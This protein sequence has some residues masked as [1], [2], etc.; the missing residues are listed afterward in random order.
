M[1]NFIHNFSPSPILVDFGFVQIH[2]YGLFIALAIVFAWLLF[3]YLAKWNAWD[4]K[5]TENVILS[6][7][8]GAVLGARIYYIVYAWQFYREDCLSIFKI[9]EGGLA[10]HGALIGG[11]VALLIYCRIKKVAVLPWLDIFAVVLPLSQA[12]GRW[13]NYFNQEIF[14]KPTTLPW[15]IPITLDK[16]PEAYLLDNYF[17]PTFLYES[18]LN[19][20]LFALLFF[21]WRKWSAKNP[22]SIFLLYLAVY[23]LIR[24][25]MEFLRT[26]YSPELFGIR[27]AQGLSGMLVIVVVFIILFKFKEIVLRCWTKGK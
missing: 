11:F 14:G 20:I 26:D 15:G 17:H 6:W 1:F 13:G 3:S 4:K 27:W 22:G 2:W 24:F 19:L 9:W 16:R 8:I 23:S 21:L 18:L 7:L 25:L 12:I 10:I 5:T